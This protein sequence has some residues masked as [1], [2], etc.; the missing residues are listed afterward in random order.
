VT[1]KVTAGRINQIHKPADW[2]PQNQGSLE[3]SRLGYGGVEE[4]REA[5][6]Q[7]PW[8]PGGLGMV[9]NSTFEKLQEKESTKEC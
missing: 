5:M 1:W 7:K 8:L 6:E 4:F 3:L 9:R 2:S